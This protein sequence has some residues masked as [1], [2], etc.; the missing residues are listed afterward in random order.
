M[1]VRMVVVVGMVVCMLMLQGD[2]DLF[3]AAAF[4]A[5]ISRLA[6]LGDMGIG[7]RANDWP[8]GSSFEQHSSGKTNA[9]LRISPS[10]KLER[11]KI[12]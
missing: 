3:L 11:D 1:P 2:L 7:D 6:G 12:R 10:P 5:T 4:T 8:L 9:A